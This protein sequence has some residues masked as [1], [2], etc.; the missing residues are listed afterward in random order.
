MSFVLKEGNATAFRGSF[1]RKL[2]HKYCKALGSYILIADYVQGR[3]KLT[4]RHYTLYFAKN[5]SLFQHLELLLKMLIKVRGS[6]PTSKIFLLPFTF[7]R[8]FTF[9]LSLSQLTWKIFSSWWVIIISTVLPTLTVATGVT[10]TNPAAI[11]GVHLEHSVPSP[12]PCV[13][14]EKESPVQS[15][16]QVLLCVETLKCHSAPVQRATQPCASQYLLLPQS[17]PML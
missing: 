9:T 6:H 2:A 4:R 16:I 8:I 10:T 7:F 11:Y 13:A 5:N 3:K 14:G 12:L 1:N 15:S 17:S